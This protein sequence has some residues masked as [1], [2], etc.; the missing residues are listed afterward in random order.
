MLIFPFLNPVS[1]ALSTRSLF[2]F[3]WYLLWLDQLNGSPPPK[4][5]TIQRRYTKNFLAGKVTFFD[6]DPTINLCAFIH[7]TRHVSFR[8]QLGIQRAYNSDNSPYY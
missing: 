6:A 4:Y 7:Q 8:F 1:A 3:Q 2:C 5:K